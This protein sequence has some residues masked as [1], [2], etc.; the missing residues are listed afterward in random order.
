[1]ALFVLVSILGTLN[2]TVLV[3]P[4]IAYAMALDGRFFGG[5][6]RV[7]AAHHTPHVAIVLQGAVAVALLLALRRFPSILDFTTFGIVV[8]T[9][10][11]TL[12]LFALRWRQPGRRRP[13]RAW[14]YP[15]VPA[16]YL[17]ANLAIAA[18]MV[19]GRPGESLACLLVTLAGLPFYLAFGRRP[20]A[21]GPP[22]TP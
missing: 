4:R 2:A 12:A 22:E 10:L 13:Y 18:A 15:W 5:V 6:D 21:G 14:G 11:D 1:V 17:A 9:S 8:A 16:L 3:G 7:H 19:R 20:R